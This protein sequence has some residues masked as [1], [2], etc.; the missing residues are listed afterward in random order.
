MSRLDEKEKAARR[1]SKDKAIINTRAKIAKALKGFVPDGK[2][3]FNKQHALGCGHAKCYL[4]HRDK[5]LKNKT[6]KE[7]RFEQKDKDA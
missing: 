4:C 2:N 7:K 5:L 1:R 6:L 3:R